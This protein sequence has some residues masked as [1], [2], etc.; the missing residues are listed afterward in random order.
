[1]GIPN[2]RLPHQVRTQND[3]RKKLL[4]TEGQPAKEK[5]LK[6]AIA[7]AANEFKKMQ[8]ARG[9]W[10][11]SDEL[12]QVIIH[13]DWRS[14]KIIIEQFQFKNYFKR[15]TTYYFKKKDLIDLGKGMKKR[16]INLEKY[17]ELLRDKE[18]FEKYISSIT[19]P[20]G[21]KKRKRYK[22]PE[23][24][25]NIYSEPYSHQMKNW[26]GMK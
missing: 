21:K 3:L 7:E 24:L 8:T 9:E 19:N 20:D 14:G 11:S 22:I 23:G 18:K 1:V 16:N 6:S 5:F 15:G 4:G 13:A 2:Q 17:D 26:S 10:I 25:E 12:N